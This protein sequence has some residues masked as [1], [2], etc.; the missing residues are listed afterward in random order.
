MFSSVRY[1]FA[2]WFVYFVYFYKGESHVTH[3]ALTSLCSKCQLWMPELPVLP[4]KWLG[5]QLCIAKPGLIICYF[6]KKNI[7]KN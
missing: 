6:K 1:L 3:V 7:L 2:Y 5:C 4:L